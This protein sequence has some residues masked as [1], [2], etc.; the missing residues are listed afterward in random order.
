VEK[1]LSLFIR[2]TVIEKGHFLLLWLAFS[3]SD[4][5]LSACEPAYQL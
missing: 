4:E 2:P 3:T 5:S 1:P